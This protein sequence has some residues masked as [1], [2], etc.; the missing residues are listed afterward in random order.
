MKNRWSYAL[1]DH[2]IIFSSN[3][4]LDD[5]SRFWSFGWILLMINK[6]FF[7]A[8]IAWKK[9]CKCF[10]MMKNNNWIKK[11][12]LSLNERWKR[13]IVSREENWKDSSFR[14]IWKLFRFESPFVWKKMNN[15][16]IFENF[17]P[18]LRRDFFNFY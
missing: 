6:W 3:Q 10:T 2:Q 13:P 1:Y 8:F 11:W 5:Y 9:C 16:Q 7:N 14:Y 12:H 18:L 17:F 15:S 4:F